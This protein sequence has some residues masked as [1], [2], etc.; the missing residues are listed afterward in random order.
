MS[1][2][3][4]KVLAENYRERP[5]FNKMVAASSFLISSFADV[6]FYGPYIKLVLSSW[7]GHMV[8]LL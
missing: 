2:K 3:F 4:K 8:T 7:D 6:F 5:S 1:I